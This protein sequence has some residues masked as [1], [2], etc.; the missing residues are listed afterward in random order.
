MH[1]FLT[2]GTGLIGTAVVAELTEHGHTA[3]VLTR[4]DASA[5]TAEAAGATALRG[6][7]AVSSWE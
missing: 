4:S 3:T 1:V 5:A 2:G 6:G 7:K